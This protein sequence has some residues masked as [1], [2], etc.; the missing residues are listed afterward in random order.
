MPDYPI[1]IET[2]NLGPYW[3]DVTLSTSGEVQSYISGIIK[4]I[5][6]TLNKD[7]KVCERVKGC[8]QFFTKECIQKAGL[9]NEKLCHNCWE[10]I[11]YT[12]RIHKIFKYNPVWWHFPDIID[13][14]EYIKLQ[15]ISGSI[16]QH[17][18]KILEIDKN[19][20]FKLL[21]WNGFPLV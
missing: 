20:M 11:E 7:V 18:K 6:Y 10:H 2:N 4:D 3:V 12:A 16:P 15:K 17:N 14:Y 9:M 1:M 8:F 5:V 21:G 19:L 13:S